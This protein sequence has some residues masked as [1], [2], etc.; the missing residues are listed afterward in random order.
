MTIYLRVA[1]GLQETPKALSIVHVLKCHD[2]VS[3]L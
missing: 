1:I 3:Q 2:A